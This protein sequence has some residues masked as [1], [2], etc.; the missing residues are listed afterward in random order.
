M[1]SFVYLPKICINIYYCGKIV[2]LKIKSKIHHAQKI[3]S[4]EVAHRIVDTYKN[5]V[6][7]YIHHIYLTESDIAIATMCEYPQF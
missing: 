2:T 6:M 3:I 1:L 7:L 4:G 5:Y